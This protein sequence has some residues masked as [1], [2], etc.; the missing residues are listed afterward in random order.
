M[1]EILDDYADIVS[2]DIDLVSGM[3]YG[4]LSAAPFEVKPPEPA[5]FESTSKWKWILPA[6]IG[7]AVIITIFGFIMLRS[8]AR[9]WKDS[10]HVQ[11]AVDGDTSALFENNTMRFS[12][13][14][15]PLR[16]IEDSDG[17]MSGEVAYDYDGIGSPVSYN[18]EEEIKIQRRQLTKEFVMPSSTELSRLEDNLG[19]DWWTIRDAEQ[20]GRST[21]L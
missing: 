4:T 18:E 17:I 5:F 21:E 16:A 19:S 20:K 10:T 14:Q 11:V 7:G 13:M 2:E 3:Q 1:K 6:F 9:R 12:D 15:F 8:N